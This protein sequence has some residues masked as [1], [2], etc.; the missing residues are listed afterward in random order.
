MHGFYFQNENQSTLD[1]LDFF[2]LYG[3]SSE[4]HDLQV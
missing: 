4:A 2:I 1:A 3:R